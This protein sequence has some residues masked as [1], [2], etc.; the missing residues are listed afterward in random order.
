[1]ERKLQVTSSAALLAQPSFLAKTEKARKCCKEFENAE[2]QL[3]VSQ[4]G[5]CH[6]REDAKAVKEEKSKF[7]AEDVSKVGL[8]RD[9]VVELAKL[10]CQQVSSAAAGSKELVALHTKL[11]SHKAKAASL[12]EELKV[13]QKVFAA[14]K[15]WSGRKGS[16]WTLLPLG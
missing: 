2:E 8:R 1:M 15:T 9:E 13:L 6:T 7:K 14:I 5:A 11:E 4:V 3:G 10:Q 16:S 12:D